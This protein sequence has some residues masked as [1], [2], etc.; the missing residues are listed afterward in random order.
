ML[1]CQTEGVSADYSRPI[2][3]EA[4]RLDPW[5]RESVRNHNRWIDYLRPRFKMIL[6]SPRLHD[7]YPAVQIY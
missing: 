2:W 3:N 5:Q 7:F 4:P 1:K 6:I